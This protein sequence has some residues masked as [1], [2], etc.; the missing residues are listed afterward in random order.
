MIEKAFAINA[1]PETI[2]DAL[3]SEL[4][5]GDESRYSLESSSRPKRLQ[6]K[7]D[8]SGMPCLLTYTLTA[9][10]DNGDTEVAA[11]LEPQSKRYGLYYL[12][13]FGHITRNYE[14][15]LVAGLAN[16]KTHVEGGPSPDEEPSPEIMG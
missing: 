8:M 14:M 13:T 7:V 15:L 11:A 10:P 12:L 6:V 4:A 2:W 3:W 5:E 1:P 16:L 9:R